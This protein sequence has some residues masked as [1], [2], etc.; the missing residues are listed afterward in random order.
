VFAAIVLLP[1]AAHADDIGDASYDVGKYAESI[2]EAKDY[3]G[4]IAADKKPADCTAAVAR[5]RKAG[6][7][8]LTSD[9]F[10]PTDDITLEQADKLCK[11][12]A[13]YYAI[14]IHGDD[15]RHLEENVKLLTP[16][17]APGPE[18]VKKTLEQAAQCTAWAKDFAAA[19]IPASFA[20]K[21]QDV[22]YT[23]GDLKAKLC[24]VA[25][26]AAGQFTKEMADAAKKEQ[27]K[28]SKVG[29]AGDKLE[30]MLKYDGGVVLPGGD[31]SDDLKQYAA[32]S[33]LFVWTTSDADSAGFVVH[34]VRKYQFTGNKLVAT[35]EKTYRKKKGDKVG[36]VFN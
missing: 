13:Q 31:S 20:F 2:E 22:A 17:M 33:A 28:Y 16:R 1:L 15:L 23:V 27:Q 21:T 24:D 34:T 32:A 36:A 18:F 19:G 35:T 9:H 6:A 14:G 10:K 3:I 7:K 25:V 4:K 26:K 29:I 30:L 12:Y 11:E 5:A 8:T